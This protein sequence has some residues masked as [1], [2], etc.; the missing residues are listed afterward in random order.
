MEFGDTSKVNQTPLK[1][2]LDFIDKWR[3]LQAAR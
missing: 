3:A 1:E 2:K